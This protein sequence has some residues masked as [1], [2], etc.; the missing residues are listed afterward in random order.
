[1]QTVSPAD[2][3]EGLKVISTLVDTN[4]LLCRLSLKEY[5]RT[6]DPKAAAKAADHTR[7]ALDWEEQLERFMPREKKRVWTPQN[8]FLVICQREAA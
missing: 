4:R 5:Q 1:M 3:I 2:H 8:L 6:G 7:K